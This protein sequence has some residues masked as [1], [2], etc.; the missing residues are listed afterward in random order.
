MKPT[1][2]LLILAGM[3]VLQ[4]LA[5]TTSPTGRSQ[6]ILVSDEQIGQMGAQAFSQYKQEN[7][8]STNAK[9][10]R[11]V[12]CVANA[13]TPQAPGRYNWEVAVFDEEAVNA[14]AL[15]GGKIG[16]NTGLFKAAENQHQLAAVI[17]HEIAHVVARHSAAQV[18]NQL[19]TQLGVSVVAAGTGVNPQLIGMG[20]D[21]ML[22]LPYSRAAE[23]EA[24]ILG[25]DYMA[26]AGFD[27]RQSIKLWQNMQRESGARPVTFM[28][29][30]PAPQTRI[31]DLE[32]RLPQ[33]MQLY[34]QAR[35]ARRMPDCHL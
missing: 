19:A 9:I 4:L 16:V 3:A 31:R 2:T 22:T 14:F 25:L 12:N 7:K 26:S 10:N 28:S 8:L 34:E 6:L 30:H 20:A 11:Y 18:S 13:V 1:R 23:S 32:N 17:G 5:C 33:A 21:L 27:P 35:A 24:D 15:P 29:T